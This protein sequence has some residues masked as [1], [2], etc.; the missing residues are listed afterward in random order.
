MWSR[1]RGSSRRLIWMTSAGGLITL[2]CVA[3]Y[4]VFSNLFRDVFVYCQ[5]LPTTRSWGTAMDEAYMCAVYWR[6]DLIRQARPLDKLPAVRD[7]VADEV[8]M[9]KRAAGGAGGDP[10]AS[11]KPDNTDSIAELLSGGPRHAGRSVATRP[12]FYPAQAATDQSQNLKTSSGP[13]IV[14]GTSGDAERCRLPAPATFQLL[15]GLDTEP[16]RGHGPQSF[17]VDLPP[18]DLADTVRSVLDPL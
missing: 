2:C 12:R 3:V 5:R 10:G 8:Q 18:G 6:G 13:A 14:R 11:G 16:R 17:S 15:L 7:A 4:L 9:V 1:R